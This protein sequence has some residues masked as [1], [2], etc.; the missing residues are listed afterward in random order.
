[1][2]LSDLNRTQLEALATLAGYRPEADDTDSDLILVL[3]FRG[4]GGSGRHLARARQPGAPAVAGRI[5]DGRVFA[6]TVR[7]GP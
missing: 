3:R 5:V 7:K 6:P 1:M 2:R 4:W